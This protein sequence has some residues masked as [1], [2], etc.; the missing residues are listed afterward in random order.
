MDIKIVL[1]CQ[2]DAAPMLEYLRQVGSESYFL[3]F[4]PEGVPMTVEQEAKFLSEVNASPLAR[5]IIVKDGEKIIANGYIHSSS[6]ERIRHK[7][8]LAISVLKDYWGQGIG[9]R[10]MRALIDFAKSTNVVETVFL[11]VASENTRAIKLYE[12]I[13]FVRYGTC[14]KAAKVGDRYFDW[15]LMRLD[16][17]RR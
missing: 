12:K 9:S 3:L 14:K 5:M 8:E 1:A 10:L 17:P 2:E 15:D 13:G 7:A 6:R 11:E 4:G 16:L